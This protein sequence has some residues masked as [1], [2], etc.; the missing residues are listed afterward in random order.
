MGS[1][2]KL[3]RV[4]SL[5][6]FQIF[7]ADHSEVTTKEIRRLKKSSSSSSSSS[8]SNIIKD[9]NTNNSYKNEKIQLGRTLA[10]KWLNSVELQRKYQHIAEEQR[11]TLL[12]R[13]E[14]M[15]QSLKVLKVEMEVATHLIQ[16]ERL[17]DSDGVV[18]DKKTTESNEK[19]NVSSDEPERSSSSPQEEKTNNSQSKG[20][21]PSKRPHINSTQSS[22]SSPK[23]TK[24]KKT[25]D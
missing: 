25:L 9:T 20:L 5:T 6:P 18:M 1:R 2:Q 4:S 17:V 21:T 8:S 11:R 3:Q 10:E 19:T 13:E 16:G 7:C 23:T 22:S 15:K 12:L 14:F 24:K